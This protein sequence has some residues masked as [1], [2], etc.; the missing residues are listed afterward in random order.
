MSKQWLAIQS[1]QHDQSIISAINTLSIYT[2]L[3]LTGKVENTRKMAAEQAKQR[4]NEFFQEIASLLQVVDGEEL[5]PILKTDPRLSQLVEKFLS[6]RQDRQHFRSSLFQGQFTQVQQL[7]NAKEEEDQK[8]LLQCLDELRN[9]LQEH[10]SIDAEQ[11]MG[12]N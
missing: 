9:I 5:E 4:L 6:A 7:L 3:S 8:A 2:K 12:E 10:M 11:V 1:L